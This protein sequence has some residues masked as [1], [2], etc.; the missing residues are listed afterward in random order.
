MLGHE[1]K[2]GEGPDD[3]VEFFRLA[4]LSLAL[5]DGAETPMSSSEPTSS[6]SPATCA[7]DTLR[8]SQ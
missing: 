4:A 5:V 7:S 3:L 2:D 6:V 8:C 1:L